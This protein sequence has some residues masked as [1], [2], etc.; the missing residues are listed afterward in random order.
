MTKLSQVSKVL[1]SKSAGPF[2]VTIDIFLKEMSV[3]QKI[4]DSG[5]FTKDLIS[6]LYNVPKQDVLGVYFVDQAQGIKVSI[7][8]KIATGDPGCADYF[9]AQQHAPLL[10]LEVPT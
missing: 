9:Y 4:K 10:D 8:K 5:L 2:I 7:M 3:Y 6:K 1:R